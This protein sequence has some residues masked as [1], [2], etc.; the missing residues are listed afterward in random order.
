M[1]IP[2][3]LNLIGNN[4]DGLPTIYERVESVLRPQGSYWQTDIPVKT[5]MRMEADIMVTE[6]SA[7][8]LCRFFMSYKRRLQNAIFVGTI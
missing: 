2:T 6:F 5:G 3:P 1:S 7:R 4:P 8:R